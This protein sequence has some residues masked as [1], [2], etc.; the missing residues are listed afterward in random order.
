M[1]NFGVE[2]SW[3]ATTSKTERRWEH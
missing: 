1:K 3:K 2:A